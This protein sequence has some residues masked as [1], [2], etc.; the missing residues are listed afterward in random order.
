MKKYVLLAVL[1]GLVGLLSLSV[2]SAVVAQ[3]AT[4]HWWN[5]RVFYEIFVR[6]FHDSNGD[7]IGDL[8]G[9]ISKLDYLNDGDPSTDTDLGVTGLW[10]MPI[11]KSPNYHGY[12]VTAYMQVNP[13]YGT[14]DDFKQ[15]M[16]EAAKLSPEAVAAMKQA[17]IKVQADHDWQEY[18][19]APLLGVDGY[20][21]ICHGRSEAKAIK[22]AIRV[23]K[24][25]VTSNLNQLIIGKIEKSIPVSEE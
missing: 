2:D 25:L 20:S 10:L 19:G 11:F 22:N 17:M 16:T 7:G 8:Q 3:D 5:D 1:L 12:D 13:D 18:G 23:G 4:A 24:Q 21:I 15:L 6:S 9:L 14:N